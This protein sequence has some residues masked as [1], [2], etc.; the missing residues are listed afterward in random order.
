MIGRNFSKRLERLETRTMP[1]GEPLVIQVQFVSADGS[2]KD[3]P[4]FVAAGP[5]RRHL[6]K[7]PR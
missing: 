3:G 1:A 4:R 2:V 6:G 5:L 7:V